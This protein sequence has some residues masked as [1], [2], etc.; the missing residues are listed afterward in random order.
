MPESNLPKPYKLLLS[1]VAAIACVTT[2]LIWGVSHKIGRNVLKPRQFSCTRMAEPNSGEL[3]WTIII[4]Q[5]QTPKPLLRIVSGME[6]DI[7]PDRRCKDVAATLDRHYADGLETLFYRPNP[8]TP[9]RHAICIQ[10][11]AHAD[12]DCAN[13][14]I[15]K[16]NI[17]P[18][19]FFERFT[20][21]LQDL[22]QLSA[23]TQAIESGGAIATFS[24]SSD[25]P[26]IGKSL[27]NLQPWL[28]HQE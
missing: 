24:R 1:G 28:N 26:P 2:G 7:T 9:T 11:A 3:L 25:Q 18:Q 13:L 10:T 8:A 20:A 5:N 21:D 27:I 16:S 19:Q 15:L 23:P 12:E 4:Q 14:V 22:D 6:G 17:D